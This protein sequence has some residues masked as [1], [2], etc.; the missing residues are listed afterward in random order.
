MARSSPASRALLV[1]AIQFARVAYAGLSDESGETALEH[2]LRVMASLADDDL[3]VVAVL[4]DALTNPVATLVDLR[5]LLPSRLLMSVTALGHADE[6]PDG[7]AFRFILADPI[8]LEVK[9]ACLADLMNPLRLAKLDPFTRRH[10]ETAGKS[11]AANLGTTLPK[12]LASSGPRQ[13]L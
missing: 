13:K 3:K 1:D 12:L 4:H 6:E 11:A 5:A 2:P 7:I 8:A 10:R 9:L